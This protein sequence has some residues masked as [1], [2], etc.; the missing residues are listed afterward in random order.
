[1]IKVIS[2]SIYGDK[3]MYTVGLLKNLELAKNIYPDWTVYIYYN[4]TVPVDMI[5][6]Y[7][8]FDNCELFD[9]TGFS[10]PG[11]LWRFLP[12]DNV[13]R[14][15]S[16]D[17]DSRLSMREKLVVDDWIE[18]KK[19]LHII[20]DHHH[21]G[22][23]IYAG[24]FGLIVSNDLNLENDIIKYV[25]DTNNFNLFDKFSDTPFLNRFV[26]EKYVNIG[27]VLCHDSCSKNFPFSK[28]F[29]TPLQDYRFVGEIYDEN[30]NRNHDYL[31]WKDKKE[32]G[33]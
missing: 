9:M 8:D 13:E 4:N 2:F 22:I 1:M 28:P 31:V 7:K 11:V 15:I 19:T 16:R 29:P 3:P 6:K 10:G 27:D 17:A 32:I 21:H 18:S 33:Y 12:H 14:F 20:R 5:E 30:D 24:L 25:D 23:P 26:Y